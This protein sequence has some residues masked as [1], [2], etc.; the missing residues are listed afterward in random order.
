MADLADLTAQPSGEYQYVLCVLNV[1]SRELYARAM[2]VKDPET[3]TEA[4]EDILREAG[5]APS[6][7]DTDAGPEFD[8]PFEEML[9][10]H[11]IWHVVKDP[12]DKN[13]LAPIDRAVAT[14]KRAIFRNVVQEGNKN[15]QERL[16]Q[17]V[18]GINETPSRPIGDRAPEEV[19]DD[20][21]LQFR[22]RR[23][24]SEAMWHNTI[25]VAKR[26][27]ALTKQ[28]A[29]RVQ[30]PDRKHFGHRS[31]Q[32]RFGDEVHTIAPAGVDGPLVKDVD[33][34]E[35]KTR[36][37]KGVPAGSANAEHTEHMRG[38]SALIDRRQRELVEPYRERVVAFVGDEVKALQVVANYMKFA[39]MLTL[40]HGTLTYRKAITLMG[41][42]VSGGTGGY[43]SKD[44][45]TAAE[46][47][48]ALRT[49]P[50]HRVRGPDLRRKVHA[51]AAAAAA[52]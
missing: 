24:N 3:T 1:F 17:T 46:A 36:H 28:G 32:P 30:I 12:Q 40:I 7:L 19:K 42:H 20:P 14:L 22:L 5:K 2:K 35:Y 11:K 13:V 37:V 4:F 45:L 48:E 6:R 39:G 15:W 33:G 43:V 41:L 49:K 38:G 18:A 50:G 23:E 34:N 44:P 26:G 9:E 47:A 10:E 8:G 16:K 52:L 25:L 51:A 27:D 31:Y 29:F 21:E